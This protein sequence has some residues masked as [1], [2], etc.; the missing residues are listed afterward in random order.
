MEFCGPG[1]RDRQTN[2]GHNEAVYEV[3]RCTTAHTREKKTINDPLT[4]KGVY[5]YV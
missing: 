2:G 4:S 5:V 3:I 1:D